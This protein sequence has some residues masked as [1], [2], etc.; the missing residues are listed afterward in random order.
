MRPTLMSSNPAA[1]LILLFFSVSV[2]EALSL[3]VMASVT[4]SSVVE[5][6]EEESVQNEGNPDGI[7]ARGDDERE[8]K[9]NFE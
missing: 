3:P 1:S 6:E 9:G 4:A 5:E 2:S 8:K 7:A